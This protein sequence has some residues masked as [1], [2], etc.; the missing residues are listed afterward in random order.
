MKLIKFLPLIIISV[1]CIF[2]FFSLNN[3]T[4]KLS[5]PL[6]GKEVP[7]FSVDR[8]FN[9]EKMTNK[10]LITY[11]PTVLNIWSSWCIPCRAEHDV[12]MVLS[13]L[14]DVDIY[15]L[16][17][18]DNE[19]EAKKFIKGL[20]NPFKKIGVDTSGRSAIN[21][22]VYGVPET[23]IIK[24][25]IIIYKHIGPI[26]MNELDEKILPLIKDLQ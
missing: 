7:E 23:F 3:D 14:Y 18:K 4:T 12:L 19:T 2:F 25:G 15:G 11:S 10:D 21:L 6:V 8:L 9:N 13:E 26:H 5:S 22:G 16:N 17:Y 24:N 20:G 1:V